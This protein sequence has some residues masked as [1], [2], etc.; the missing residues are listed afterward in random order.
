MFE[1]WTSPFAQANQQAQ[2]RATAWDAIKADPG[3]A[4]LIAGLSLLSNNN[5]SRSFGQLV[6]R[7]GFD[8]L[9]GL[10]SME[11]QRQAQERYQQEQDIALADAARKRQ[12]DAFDMGMAL[13]QYQLDRDKYQ[14]DKQKQE[15]EMRGWAMLNPYMGGAT[16]AGSGRAS[17]AP[18]SSN[19]LNMRVP[20]GADFQSFDSPSDAFTS[21]LGQFKRYQGRG[22]VTPAQMI[23]GD[24]VNGQY[25]PGWAPAA[26][27]NDTEA[28]IGNVGKWTG[29]DM[30]APIN[31]DDPVAVSKLISGMAR[32]EQRDGAKWTPEAV[33]G[34]LYGGQ[35]GGD[36]PLAPPVIPESA[37]GTNP[38]APGQVPDS[39][40][41]VPVSVG[42]LP[43]AAGTAGR[44]LYDQQSKRDQLALDARKTDPAFIMAQENAKAVPAKVDALFNENNTLSESINNF[45]VLSSLYARGLETGAWAPMRSWL[46]N[47]AEAL[48][49]GDAARVMGLP[50]VAIQ[51]QFE[52]LV[53]QN[54]FDVLSQQKGVQTEGDAQRAAQ[55]WASIKNLPEANMW[56]AQLQKNVA[57]RQIAINNKTMELLEKH[58]GNMRLVNADIQK[59]KDSLPSIVPDD[60]RRQKKSIA[61]DRLTAVPSHGSSAEVLDFY[62]IMNR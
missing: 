60:P 62:D 58:S 56:I 35:G 50:D 5:G 23:A 54:V 28:Y 24:D 27:G 1:G 4:A 15:A 12:K 9:V 14:L 39:V 11:A 61:S 52:N 47:Q 20:G 41:R 57:Q 10:G 49:L 45:E 3:T 13:N 8:S 22:L 18:N 51:Q 6:G 37:K 19:P 21:Y 34:A 25:V 40:P 29:L 2:D 48:G 36:N 16:S 17:G 43:G 26:D 46:A 7:A 30:H 59:F 38:L 31:L 42:M 44:W 55:T 32:M 53:T 33:R